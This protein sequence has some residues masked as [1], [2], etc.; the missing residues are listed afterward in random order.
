MIYGK[1]IRTILSIKMYTMTFYISK[2]RYSTKL[3]IQNIEIQS[4]TFKSPMNTM[5]VF[6]SC[7]K[8]TGRGDTR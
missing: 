5:E 2:N 8:M 3:L 1:L 7:H 6:R 4:I